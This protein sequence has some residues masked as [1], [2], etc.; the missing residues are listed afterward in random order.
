VRLAIREHH[1]ACKTATSAFRVCQNSRLG[2]R[3]KKRGG[4]TERVTHVEIER[5]AN[6]GQ[7]PQ[8]AIEPPDA[9]MNPIS[10]AYHLPTAVS[11][12]LGQGMQEEIKDIDREEGDA[13]EQEGLERVGADLGI[14]G[15]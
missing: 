4:R 13:I 7:K 1:E 6:D 11:L 15:K 10:R 8:D 9:L 14:A 2:S 5:D 3:G 12:A